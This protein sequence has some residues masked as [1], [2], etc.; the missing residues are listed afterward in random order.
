MAVIDELEGLEAW[1]EI[2]DQRAQEYSK[3]DDDDGENNIQRLMSTTNITSS[4]AL[5]GQSIPH[6]VKYIEAVP[7]QNFN[8]CFQ[9][10]M[11]FPRRC[12]HLGITFTADKTG[13][14]LIHEPVQHE[15]DRNLE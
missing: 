15:G 5:N 8:I 4:V 9:K 2:N 7:D 3:P 6:V 12:D 10:A 11:G 14:F 1:V 13:T